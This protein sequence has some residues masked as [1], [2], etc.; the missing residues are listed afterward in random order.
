MLL[1]VSLYA[2]IKIF[3]EKKSGYSD[4]RQAEELV[5]VRGL[6]WYWRLIA[7]DNLRGDRLRL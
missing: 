1:L 3:K 4:C 5:V 6:R 7:Q 2:G